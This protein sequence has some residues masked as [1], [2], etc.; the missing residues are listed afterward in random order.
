MTRK[1]LSRDLFFII[2]II[3]VLC[4]C[5]QDNNHDICHETDSISLSEPVQI[6][7]ERSWP[8][9]LPSNENELTSI[10]IG[11]FLLYENSDALKSENSRDTLIFENGQYW[12]GTIFPIKDNEWVRT[13]NYQSEGYITR[14]FTNSPTFANKLGLRTGAYLKEFFSDIAE[15]EPVMLSGERWYY[16]LS[17]G[18]YLKTS[19]IKTDF[20]NMVIEEIGIICGDC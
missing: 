1:I 16:S 15:L 9:D 12:Q 17:E 6:K 7:L 14:I 2:P 20:S 5:R 13:E 11:K 3:L 10:G 8:K 19:N 4:S 18:I